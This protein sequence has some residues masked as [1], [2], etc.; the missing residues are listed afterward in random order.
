MVIPVS[1]PVLAAMLSMALRTTADRLD[2]ASTLPDHVVVPGL[3][4]ASN[5][6][7]VTGRIAYVRQ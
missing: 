1:E 5:F 3:T 4:E 2:P 7:F 6:I